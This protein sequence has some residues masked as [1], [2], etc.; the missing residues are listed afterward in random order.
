MLSEYH[1]L[2]RKLLKINPDLTLKTY[3]DIMLRDCTLPCGY[4]SSREDLMQ[5]NCYPKEYRYYRTVSHY[6]ACIYEWIHLGYTSL[7]DQYMVSKFK[8]KYLQTDEYGQLV[9]GHIFSTVMY[10]DMYIPID[11]SI[12]KCPAILDRV[13]FTAAIQICQQIHEQ[14]SVLYHSNFVLYRLLSRYYSKDNT[15][16]ILGYRVYSAEG[17]AQG[18]EWIEYDSIIYD[19]QSIYE[20]Y[21]SAPKDSLNTLGI[22]YVNKSTVGGYYYSKSL[23]S[24]SDLIINPRVSST[25]IDKETA[26]K[27]DDIVQ[28]CS[29][30]I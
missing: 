27:I 22:S 8:K 26:A 1:E 23:Y 4:I 17:I 29:K 9:Y 15:K 18:T 16:R 24:E 2:Y 14:D 7:Y 21:A 11:L 12:S 13:V 30:Y 19:M 5:T 25:D 6:K 10:A 20:V 3:D 28:Y